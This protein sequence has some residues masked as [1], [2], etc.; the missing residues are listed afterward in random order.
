MM[1][2]RR[3]LPILVSTGCLVALA[4][5][6]LTLSSVSTSCP[7]PH[8]Q[9]TDVPNRTGMKQKEKFVPDR[10]LQEIEHMNVASIMRD[11]KA[12][13]EALRN[14]TGFLWFVHLQKAGGT[15]VCNVLQQ[16]LIESS[17]PHGIVRSQH[18]CY[19]GGL[20]LT[21]GCAHDAWLNGI[22]D[23]VGCGLGDVSIDMTRHQWTASGGLQDK[24]VPAEVE[25][26]LLRIERKVKGVHK[27]NWLISSERVFMPRAVLRPWLV[28]RDPRLVAA[29]SKWS[30]LLSI[31]HP[32]DRLYS[33]FHFHPWF[34]PCEGNFTYC[35]STVLFTEGPHRNKL[36]K[37]LSGWYLPC[38]FGPVT[39][40]S[41][42]NPSPSNKRGHFRPGIEFPRCHRRPREATRYDLILAKVVLR[43]FMPSVI[44]ESKSSIRSSVEY[45]LYNHSGRV[46][47][48]QSD[49]VLNKGPQR[50]AISRDDYHKVAAL[51]DLDMELYDFAVSLQS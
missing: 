35:L 2:T 6:S 14:G 50:P 48:T 38:D 47:D 11:R 18:A 9:G 51:N 43:R 30:F 34:E 13:A 10:F 4:V 36:V 33:A 37:E 21:R 41:P 49:N 45:A 40:P 19:L 28:D 24:L 5:H 46:L 25:K 22:K 12:A 16:L 32:V 27:D 17:V 8:D 29:F 23:E 31:R 44:L 42:I 20:D 7:R 26:H 15:S 39:I 1:R 3:F